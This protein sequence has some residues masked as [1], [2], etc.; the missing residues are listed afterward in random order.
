MTIR[1]IAPPW[2]LGLL[3]AAG[4]V[5]AEVD[6]NKNDARAGDTRPGVLE[7][8]DHQATDRELLDGRPGEDGD[9]RKRNEQRILEL[10]DESRSRLKSDDPGGDTQKVQAEIVR[11]LDELLEQMRADREQAA[12]ETP[13][14][15]VCGG[16]PRD[17]G[18]GDDPEERPAKRGGGKG[19]D[20]GDKPGVGGAAGAESGL[21]FKETLEGW[22]KVSP[23]LRKPV[24]EGAAEEV[25]EKYRSLVRDYYRTVAERA[26]AER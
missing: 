10:M 6:D 17:G 3:A 19:D 24:M 7:R 20:A 8:L 21:E 25:V 11:R 26:V 14:G 18:G 9:E 12:K 1:R 4:T 15:T 2:L 5:F 22:A 23:R 13:G 16:K